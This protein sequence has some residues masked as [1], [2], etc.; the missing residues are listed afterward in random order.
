VARFIAE[1]GSNHNRDADRA[2]RLVESSA[3]AGC[4]AVKL[5]VFR[6]DEL[7]APEA[8]AWGPHLGA[9]RE[10]E[11]PLEM[12]PDLRAQ[13]DGLGLEL[14]V[15]PFSLWVV[16]AVADHVDFFKIASYELLWHELVR[17][18]AATGKPVVLST[19]MASEDEIAAAVDVGGDRL[20][21]LH[22]VSGY[23]TPPDQCN[24]SAIDTLRRRF[25]R[26]VGWSDHS[27]E[28]T[29]VAR[30][31]RRWRACDVELHVDLDGRGFEAGEHN[32][33]STRIRA[34]LELIADDAEPGDYAM[35]GDGRKLAQPVERP[36]VSWRADPS[37]G[38]RP[39]RPVRPS[40]SRAPRAQHG[41]GG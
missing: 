22:C 19:G 34:M 38:L 29:V 37:D 17:A 39:L 11:F 2:H 13:C 30:A 6:I 3:R 9:R 40:L 36:D 10:W 7:F 23:P 27:G 41:A 24:L 20:T 16:D 35:D 1:I 8:L 4:S 26:P 28:P 25:G 33:N 5:Q 31:V 14:G 21:L 12:L 15:T 32:W 18:C